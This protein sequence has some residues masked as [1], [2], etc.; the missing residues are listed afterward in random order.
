MINEL[1]IYQFSKNELLA[2]NL[3]STCLSADERERAEK[4]VF[5]E[6]RE[7]FVACRAKLRQI[8]GAA[9]N[10]PP[11]AMIFTY[12][13]SGKPEL[14][15]IKFN[16]SHTKERLIIATHPEYDIGVDIE[17][18]EDKDNTDI[19]KRFFHPDEIDIY[20]ALSTQERKKAFYQ[21]WVIKEAVA[22]ALGV[23]LYQIMGEIS[24]TGFA[25]GVNIQAHGK[26][27]NK[28]KIELLPFENNHY[29]AIALIVGARL[30][31]PVF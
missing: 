18:Y 31:S 8:L 17:R 11:Q 25:D 29:A 28:L 22:K 13:P 21:L 3:D 16:V 9:L 12:N 20:L 15:E 26:L 10:C 1:K 30:A 14:S 5:D 19:M 27:K 7:W 2:E 4:F 23:S 24:V 6:D